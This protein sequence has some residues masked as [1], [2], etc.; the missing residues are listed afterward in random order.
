MMDD[1]E[2]G[3]LEFRRAEEKRGTCATSRMPQDRPINLSQISANCALAVPTASGAENAI[4]VYVLF[5][6]HTGNKVVMNTTNLA[7]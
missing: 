1:G 6:S 2:S 3:L 7:L 4:L 5:C